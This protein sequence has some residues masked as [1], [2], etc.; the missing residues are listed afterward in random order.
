MK[1]RGVEVLFAQD[2]AEANRLV[3]DIARQHDVKSVVKSKSMVTEEME[4]NH[5]L[6]EAGIRPVETD[7]GE[8]IVQLARQRPIHLV[9]PAMHFSA[10][11]VGQLFHEKL[12]EPYSAEHAALTAIARKHL[13]AEY[14]AAGMGISG[15][16]FAVADSGTVVVVENEGNAGLSTATPPVHVVLVGIEKVIP[17]IDH[18]P[19]FLNLL[20][21]SG[22]GQKL[23]TYTHLIHGPAP[24]KKLYVI[25]LDNGR[26]K[27]L[28][29]PHAW[30]SLFCIRCGACLNACPV[31]RRVG[32][33]SY[34]WVYPGPIG[35][36]L[37]PHLVGLDKAGKLP[38]ASS[39]CGACGEV[40]PV[41]IDIPHQLVHLRYRAVNE[42]SPMNSAFERLAVE[43]LGLG[44]GW[45]A[46]LWP[47]DVGGPP[48]SAD[49]KVPALA[50]GQARRLD[51]RAGVAQGSLAFL[52]QLVAAAVQRSQRRKANHEQPRH[53]PPAHSQRTCQC[54][55]G[56]FRRS[57][58]AARA[59]SLAAHESGTSGARCRSFR[60][61][62]KP[63]KG[64]ADPLPDD[65]RR[66][67][68]ACPTH[69]NGPL[70]PPRQLGPPADAGTHGRA[71]GRSP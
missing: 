3:L 18:L 43:A 60:P 35:S 65:G 8:Y 70:G 68:A 50:S 7:L 28:Q 54:R 33:W 13:R 2:A 25:F 38:F 23:T 17:K 9:T 20:G 71:S 11:E 16:N 56:R 48:R 53:Y 51:P 42:P 57:P 41:K 66:P 30:Q 19:L 39:L 21:R 6:E 37:T 1:A 15:C 12:G 67:P 14:L 22:T 29:D 34:G 31:Y 4:L 36:V 46:A 55:G 10:A 62:W 24:G 44:D 59:R 26:T 64:E 58:R 69:G 5:V 45:A 49:G 27:V 52:P 40:C 63:L 47:G 61:S 32:G